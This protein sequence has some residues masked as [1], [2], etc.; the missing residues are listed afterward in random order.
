MQ[1]DKMLG[2]M[3]T[4]LYSIDV[5][6]SFDFFDEKLNGFEKVKTYYEKFI[7]EWIKT[8][9]NPIENPIIKYF[10]DNKLQDIEDRLKNIE[11]LISKE[12]LILYLDELKG[13][14]TPDQIIQKLK[15]LD[16]ETYVYIELL[17]ENKNVKK[18]NLIGDWQTKNKIVSVKSILELDF[19]YQI[20]ENFLTS[21]FYIKEFEIMREYNSIRLAKIKNFNYSFRNVLLCFLRKNLVKIIGKCDKELIN[22]SFLQETYY[23]ENNNLKIQT[24][25]Y[26]NNRNNK[27]ITFNF[28]YKNE[29]IYSE[30]EMKFESDSFKNSLYGITYDSNSFFMEI[31]N[32]NEKYIFKQLGEKIEKLNEDFCKF[33][34][35][36]Q[37]EISFEGWIVF[38]KHSKD[39]EYF[40]QKEKVFV[41]RIKSLR[42]IL[43]YKI[44][45]CIL[46]QF[47]FNK[48]KP[49][50]FEI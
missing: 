27:E 23:D 35:K 49:I 28:V 48:E 22:S 26:A 40:L 3:P 46:H 24:Y 41:E 34:T 11:D 5:F 19:N 33:F 29:N 20:I 32:F 16:Y 15:S 44:K 50:I 21:L 1:G 30:I 43:N 25:S 37:N 2:K 6:K 13:Q 39:D 18:I 38:L 47:N 31:D 7:K 42:S 9:I 45:I 4:S 10:F 17:K 12:N 14:N 8:E 36:K